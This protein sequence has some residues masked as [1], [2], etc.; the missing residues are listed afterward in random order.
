MKPRKVNM[1]IPMFN[2]KPAKKEWWK[3]NCEAVA[4]A[5][6]ANREEFL[7]HRKKV[8]APLEKNVRL[9]YLRLTP[10]DLAT[11]DGKDFREIRTIRRMD[12][13]NTGGSFPPQPIACLVTRFTNGP[14]RV[15]MAYQYSSTDPFDKFN[16]M[17]GRELALNRLAKQPFT[18]SG[19]IGTTA[20]QLKYAATEC[21]SGKAL[22][23]PN[24][25]GIPVTKAGRRIVMSC[26]KWLEMT[27]LAMQKAKETNSKATDES[28]QA[29]AP[30]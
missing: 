1:E 26:I 28:F 24:I 20:K 3:S 19:P 27:D 14:D 22:S 13:S 25:T 11:A 12:M 8:F 4:A 7:A 17:L 23:N 15:V 30:A 6:I 5:V 21:L 18:V 29:G 16:K 9:V 2:P 10:L